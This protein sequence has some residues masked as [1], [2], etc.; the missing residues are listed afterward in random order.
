MTPRPHPSPQ[1][2]S[3][4]ATGAGTSCHPVRQG[5][6]QT[7]AGMHV[8]LTF[9]CHLGCGFDHAQRGD[10]HAGVVGGAHD[11]AELQHVAANRHLILLGELLSPHHPLH[12]GH[13][14]AHRNASQVHAATWHHLL[15]AGRDGETRSHTAHCGRRERGTHG[16]GRTLRRMEGQG[17]LIQ[18]A[19]LVRVKPTSE[20]G[21]V[22]SLG[23]SLPPPTTPLLG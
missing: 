21:G 14:C 17:P 3:S 4:P 10:G 8:A 18:E 13:R 23:P 20:T 22:E 15:A 19:P 2:P 16:P 11:I 12:V 5:G 7:T 6:P 1:Q 9:H